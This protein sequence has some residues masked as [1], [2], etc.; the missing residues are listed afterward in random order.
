MT[1]AMKDI[2]RRASVARDCMPD[3]CQLIIQCLL[4]VNA[5]LNKLLIQQSLWMCYYAVITTNIRVKRFKELGVL[6]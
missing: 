4:R 3:G 1:Y 6:S 5:L 2:G